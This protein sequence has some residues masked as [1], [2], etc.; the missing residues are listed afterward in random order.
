MCFFDIV[1]T[2]IGA[3]LGF[4]FGYLLEMIIESKKRQNSIKNLKIELNDILNTLK[5]HKNN[6]CVLNDYH[7][8]IWEAVK[9]SG[10]IL[11]YIKKPYY[12]QLIIVYSKIENLQD[13]EKNADENDVNFEHVMKKIV[14][15]RND[16]YK[17]LVELNV[18]SLE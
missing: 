9:G 4:V 16:T 14:K 15:K 3:F 10:D 11:S 2:A 1:N 18:N 8:P 5:N 17:A 12:E 7:T 13:I 6:K